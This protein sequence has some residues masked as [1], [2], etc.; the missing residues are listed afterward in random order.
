MLSVSYA[1]C[2]YAECRYADCRYAECRGAHRTMGS[3]KN[4]LL[5]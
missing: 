1:E 5:P 2:R 3:S 4:W